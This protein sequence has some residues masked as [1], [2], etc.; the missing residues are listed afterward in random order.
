MP[1][2]KTTKLKSKVATSK[3]AK[4]IKGKDVALDPVELDVE[5]TEPDD[6]ELAVVAEILPKAKPRTN[7]PRAPKN[8]IDDFLDSLDEERSS[9]NFD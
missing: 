9:Q 8:H 1:L 3:S 4:N 6:E 7:T 2:K 5:A